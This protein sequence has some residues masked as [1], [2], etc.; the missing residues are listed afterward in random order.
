LRGGAA[1]TEK[2]K[3]DN[4]AEAAGSRGRHTLPLLLDSETREICF[5]LCGSVWSKPSATAG[6]RRIDEFAGN[7]S[8][9][10]AAW[11]T[12]FRSPTTSDW[13]RCGPRLRRSEK[14]PDNGGFAAL[15][16]GY[17]PQQA[18]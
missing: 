16:P 1:G 8:R 3:T 13:V 5:F 7:T 15:P 18:K 2:E 6:E 11:Q 4:D 12:F 10:F 17:V 9:G 14:A